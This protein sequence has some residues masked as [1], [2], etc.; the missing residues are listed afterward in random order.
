MTPKQKRKA[1][2]KKIQKQRDKSHDAE[3][4]AVIA[5]ANRL[6]RKEEQKK[7]WESL[8]SEKSNLLQLES[9]Y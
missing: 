8:M 3:W 4:D 5:E 1:S 7:K 6:A 9:V 2:Y